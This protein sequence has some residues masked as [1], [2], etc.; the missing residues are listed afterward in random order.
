MINKI[1]FSKSYQNLFKHYLSVRFRIYVGFQFIS[2]FAANIFE[3][4]S[5]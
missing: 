2:I 3:C 5:F 4:T 1:L